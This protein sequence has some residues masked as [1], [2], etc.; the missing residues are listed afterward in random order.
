M[1]TL[2]LRFP[3]RRYHGTPWGHHVNEGQIE[4]PPSPWRLLR[5]LLA[6]GYNTLGWD[7]ELSKPWDNRPPPV[8]LALILKL[9]AVVPT[10]TLPDAAGAHSRH[11]MP[12]GTIDKGRERT[13]LVFD[14][15]AQV[16]GE[17][18]AVNW[19]ASLSAAEHDALG[20]LADRLGYL[21]RS[22]SWVAARLLSEG[23]PVPEPNCFPEGRFSH[24]GPGW[25]QVPVLAPETPEAFAAWREAALG[26]ALA[27]FPLPAGK[28]PPK[29]L[30]A[31]R[32]QAEEPYPADLAACLQTDTAWLRKHGWS[33]PPGARRVFYWRRS[34]ALESGAPQARPRKIAA[35]TVEAMLLSIAT[36]SGND[37][38]LPVITRTL[39]Q[40]ELLHQ[41]L[42]SHASAIGGHSRVLT[43]CDEQ[44]NPLTGAHEHAHLLPLDLD[45]DE[46]LEHI[47]IWAPMGL[48]AAAQAAIRSVRRTFTKGGDTPLKIAVEAVG[49]LSSLR[50]LPA[51]Y[52]RRLSQLIGPQQGATTWVSLTPF[53]APRYVKPRGKNS[54][55]GQVRDELRVRGIRQSVEMRRLDPWSDRPAS[56]ELVSGGQLSEGVG[57]EQRKAEWMRFRHFVRERRNGPAA[58]VAFGFALELHFAEPVNG[59]I[60][61][62]YGGHFGLGLFRSTPVDACQSG[63]TATL[64]QPI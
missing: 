19:D 44:R 50:G 51:R 31:K 57:P 53:V 13:T 41:A 49:D 42:V 26:Q 37:H 32:A 45:G 20:E 35:P 47:L 29:P 4:W 23:E 52:G 8:P 6:T 28:K 17:T 14:T 33:Q 7:G 61:L 10:Y 63:Q 21:G 39:P 12:L 43:G 25:E 55:E 2:L 64:G 58:P 59:P 27:V 56:I 46:H 3:S 18:L 15:W 24:P 48:D 62:G 60:C 22:E 38:A 11:Y 16:D 5:A 30:L 54:L 9:A 36:Q 34:D 40:A 1:P